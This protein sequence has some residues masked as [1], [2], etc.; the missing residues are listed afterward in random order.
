MK[1]L[2]LIPAESICL[3]FIALFLI[4][5][6]SIPLFVPI[7][8]ILYPLLINSFAIVYAG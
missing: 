1:D 7:Q 6:F 5:A 3:I 8:I 4:T 2:P